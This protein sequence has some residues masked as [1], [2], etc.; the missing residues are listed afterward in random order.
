MGKQPTKSQ[1]TKQHSTARSPQPT[2]PPTP[3]TRLGTVF[4]LATDGLLVVPVI[5][6]SPQ[7]FRRPPWSGGP[8]FSAFQFINSKT[9]RMD[10]LYIGAQTVGLG[11]PT[12]ALP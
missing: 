8:P 4:G 9:L 5:G 7:R 12:L 1:Q 2:T 11:R 3:H 6:G 10:G